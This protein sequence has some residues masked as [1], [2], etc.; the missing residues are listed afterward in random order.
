MSTVLENIDE[1]V[2]ALRRERDA[3][4]EQVCRIRQIVG[5]YMQVRNTH[6]GAEEVALNRI[7]EEL[8]R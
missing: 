4:H 2:G 8:D 3:A 5:E 6:V 7:A 1:A